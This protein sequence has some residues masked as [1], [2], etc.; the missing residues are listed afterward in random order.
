MYKGHEKN[1]C[2]NRDRLNR[3]RLYLEIHSLELKDNLINDLYHN[4]MFIIQN[5]K[6]LTN[7]IFSKR[8]QE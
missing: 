1:L 4:K 5:I 2:I 8:N 7:K 3:V 6:I